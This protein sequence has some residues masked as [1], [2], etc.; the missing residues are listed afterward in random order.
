MPDNEI[1]VYDNE[2]EPSDSVRNTTDGHFIEDSRLNLDEKS[3]RGRFAEAN[4]IRAAR[5]LQWALW[6]L[7]LV[8]FPYLAVL[9][10]A[11]LGFL[12]PDVLDASASLRKVVRILDFPIYILALPFAV[13]VA[14]AFLAGFQSG[15]RGKG[16]I[17]P[18]GLDAGADGG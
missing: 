17:G 1:R 9:Y 16:T 7:A 13:S 12:L 5:M 15:M 18:V 14:F 11:V 4:E 6:F 2:A 3:R 8:S 10:L